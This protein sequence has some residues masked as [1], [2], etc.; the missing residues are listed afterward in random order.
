MKILTL[1]KNVL[2]KVV[3][4]NT[5]GAV[6]S[7][8]AWCCC[9]AA[10]MVPV[11][12]VAA[13][14][15]F[16]SQSQLVLLL[17]ALGTVLWR[18][19]GKMTRWAERVKQAFGLDMNRLD[20][21]ARFE[22]GGYLLWKSGLEHKAGVWRPR[23]VLQLFA[24]FAAIVTA[25]AIVVIG[26]VYLWELRVDM[27]KQRLAAKGAILSSLQYQGKKPAAGPELFETAK[28]LD[29]KKL[30]YPWSSTFG[31]WDAAGMKFAG[32]AGEH[33]RAVIDNE[34]APLIDPEHFQDPVDYAEYAKNPLEY[35]FPKFSPVIT[36]T[37]GMACLAAVEA[38]RGDLPKAWRYVNMGLDMAK[39]FIERPFPVEKLVGR[40]MYEH[41][42]NVC[43]N[44]LL[45]HPGI[46]LP[47][48]VSGKLIA[49]QD[50]DITAG[51][52]KV[53]QAW[54]FDL[55]RYFVNS[56]L[57]KDIIAARLGVAMEMI[58]SEERMSEWGNMFAGDLNGRKAA[59]DL[60]GDKI[61]RHI[62]RLLNVNPHP[63]Y[64]N[65]YYTE[66]AVRAKIRLLLLYGAMN[67][68][69]IKHG[70]YPRR[71]E[72]LAPSY[73]P[74]R[75]LKNPSTGGGIGLELLGNGKRFRLSA[76]DVPDEDKRWNTS[77]V[78]TL[79]SKI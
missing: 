36:A 23:A 49:A 54:R 41:V 48:D 35:R 53:E 3:L 29:H 50:H 46:T 4:A 21:K 58:M 19:L 42:I 2:I 76:N 26:L 44:I 11:S 43:A 59:I 27:L 70:N 65:I 51:F 39:I 47:A 31:K 17:L 68:Y 75:I 45:T 25:S 8:M 33:Y 7:A 66:I 69:K 78:L 16:L 32:K 38:A 60:H 13:D 24:R 5:A 57:R 6:L 63:R 30:P 67:S 15:P 37:R 9:V 40:Q 1:E 18:Q 64:A 12:F 62:Q 56:G 55:Q 73:I 71:L 74:P 10:A 14:T 52:M 34:I 20:Q 61:Q 77:L 79:D 22:Y 72:E 28:V